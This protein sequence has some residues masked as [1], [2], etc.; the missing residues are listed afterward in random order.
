MK[1]VLFSMIFILAASAIG[2][3]QT[4]YFPQIAAGGGW[5]TTVFVSNAKAAVTAN[6]T[7]TFTKSDSAP[8]AANWVDEAGTNVTGGGNVISFQLAP[9]QSRK[10]IAVGDLPLT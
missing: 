4:F 2:S 1:R 6:G 7:I 8:F 3:A 5:R 10:Y 9:G